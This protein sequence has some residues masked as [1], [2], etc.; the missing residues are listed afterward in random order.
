MP[1]RGFPGGVP[2][3]NAPWRPKAYSVRRQCLK[4]ATPRPQPRAC[5]PAAVTARRQASAAMRQLPPGWRLTTVCPPRS[6]GSARRSGPVP[7][8]CHW[9]TT[10]GKAVAGDD[11][12]DRQ[13][14]E[15][16]G[17]SARSGPSATSSVSP[18]GS[19]AHGRSTAPASY[20]ASAA[21]RSPSLIAWDTSST[22]SAAGGQPAA[23][24]DRAPV[25]LRWCAEWLSHPGGRGAVAAAPASQPVQGG[26]GRAPGQTPGGQPQRRPAR[27]RYS[28]VVSAAGGTPTRSCSISASSR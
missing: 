5:A 24:W 15:A 25:H 26:R 7:A 19:S 28:A 27:R 2:R 12:A 6:A 4:E 1:E 3:G 10:E 22:A 18:P 23:R 9:P 17:P 16:A 13:T 14:A 20:W 21:S 8:M 11:R